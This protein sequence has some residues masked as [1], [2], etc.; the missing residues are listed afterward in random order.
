MARGDIRQKISLEGGDEV[1]R[2]L[3]QMGQAGERAI[4][5]LGNA[6]DRVDRPYNRWG[7]AADR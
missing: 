4:N 7:A 6:A 2:Q 5:S 1:R 3:Q